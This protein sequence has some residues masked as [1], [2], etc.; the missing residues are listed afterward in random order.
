MTAAEAVESVLRVDDLCVNLGGVP[1]LRGIS[2]SVSAGRTVALI[3][4]NGAGK[5]T[6]MRAILGHVKNT[7]GTLQL[8]DTNLGG[9]AAHQRARLGIGYVPEDR[10]M[11]SSLSVEQN[12]LLP[13]HACGFDTELRTK[14]L[15]HVYT[16]VPELTKL[17]S[18]PA[19]S[20]SG[21]QQKMVALGRALMIGRRLLLLDEPF[22]GLSPALA[23]HYAEA[24]ASLRQQERQLA[25][26]VSES[27]PALLETLTQSQYTIERGEIT[28]S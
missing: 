23:R 25:I 12:I 3:G 8:A 20:L 13:A 5:T 2:L 28:Q 15:H 27:N 17:T 10:R 11:I 9:L 19:G 24:L 6:T 14:R 22:Q 16:L 1:I 21:G 7:A 18:R 26:L 4:R